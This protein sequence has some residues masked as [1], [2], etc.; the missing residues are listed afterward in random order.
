L[1]NL[2]LELIDFLWQRIN[3]DTQ[4][5]RGFINQVDCLIGQKS[6]GDVPIRK[7]RRRHD[8]GI[9]DPNS[10]VNLVTF[11]KSPENRD[12][13]FHGRFADVDLLKATFERGIL[14]DIFL[15]LI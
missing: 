4:T 9:F 8:G 1:H 11:F 12:R 2:A 15:V 6:I 3:F 13:V 14:L 7:R 5:R 10:M